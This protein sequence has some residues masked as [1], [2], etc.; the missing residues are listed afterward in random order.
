M[1]VTA[2]EERQGAEWDIRSGASNYATL[3]ITQAVGSVAAFAIVWLATRGLG[4]EGYGRVAAVVAATQLLMQVS[5]NWTAPSLTRFGCE[6][7]VKTRK[8]TNSFWTRLLILIPNILVVL[9]ISPWWLPRVGA[10]LKIAPETQPLVL[11]YMLASVLWL[12]VQHALQGAKLHRLQG[13]LQATERMVTLL[14]LLCLIMAGRATPVTTIISYIAGA[15]LALVAGLWRL[16]IL[17]FPFISLD[18][19]HFKSMLQFSLPL[20]PAALAGY[21]VGN[22]LDAIFITRYLSVADLGVYSVAYLI[23]GNFLQLPTLVSFL[24]LPMFISLHIEGQSRTIGRYFSEVFPVVVLGWSLACAFAAAGCALLLPVLFGEQYQA[25]SSLMWPMM[26]T[27][28]MSGPVLLGYG[29]VLNAWLKT[30]LYLIAVTVQ[31]GLNVIL[32]IL[33]IPRFGLYGCAWASTVACGVSLVIW[34][35]FIYRR[36]PE[37][38]FHSAAAC[39]PMVVGAACAIWL[40]NQLL[41]LMGVMLTFAI[42]F[43][44]RRQSLTAGLRVLQGIVSLN[45]SKTIPRRSEAL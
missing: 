19:P 18:L 31:G 42:F 40:G 38:R 16:R 37:A 33:L 15:T 14:V 41:V 5:L 36:I 23:V 1:I 28:A 24:L 2:E 17:I 30:D 32:N 13:L 20:V 34:A 25:V 10:W 21:L 8:I 6:E 22:F 12:H 43:L 39:L 35:Y 9:I 29:A 44:W 4:A 45:F 3:L 26:A 27:A 7:F 11:V